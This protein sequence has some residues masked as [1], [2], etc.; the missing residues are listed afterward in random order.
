MVAGGEKG[1]SADAVVLSSAEVYTPATGGWNFVGSLAMART[2]FTAD[3]LGNGKALAAGGLDATYDPLASIEEFDP[4]TNQW[5]TPPFALAGPRYY[6]T[7]TTL[8]DGSVL[9]AGGYSTG[10]GIFATNA[11]V[12]AP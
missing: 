4:A 3:L 1:H 5:S 2:S 9:I 8:L 7:G 6:H 11:E 10:F 12:F